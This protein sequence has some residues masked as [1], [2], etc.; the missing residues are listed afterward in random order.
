M[1]ARPVA[2]SAPRTTSP[3]KTR[4][5]DSAR[6]R[7]GSVWASRLPMARIPA[8]STW[9]SGR[10][11]P[12]P[13]AA[14]SPNQGYH[15]S[16]AVAFLMTV[17]NV[18]LGWW[19]QNPAKP[20]KWRT[21]GPRWGILYLLSELLG[22]ADETSRY[23]YISDGGHFENLGLYELVRRRCR[24]IVACDAGMDPGFEFEDL[25][26]A[27]RKCKVDLGVSIDIDTRP[28]RPD[29]STGRALAQCAVGTIRYERARGRDGRR[30]SPLPQALH[31][32]G[33]AR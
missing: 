31:H 10:R 26:N 20:R 15:S 1:L 29:P 18:R 14:A 11:W 8:S 3:T 9:L 12:C 32:R 13:G 33:R 6:R 7:F 28:L 22:M 19:L 27:I 17:F 25:G 21:E 5:E 16:P 24:F 23:V 30:V 2:T 4:S